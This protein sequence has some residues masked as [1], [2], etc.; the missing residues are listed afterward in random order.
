VAI[1]CPD[2]IRTQE[3]VNYRRIKDGLPCGLSESR[4]AYPHVYR[5]LLNGC[6]ACR[7]AYDLVE[8]L[9]VTAGSK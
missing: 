4:A 5:H 6:P 2:G 7:A 9:T 8:G 3:V 1:V